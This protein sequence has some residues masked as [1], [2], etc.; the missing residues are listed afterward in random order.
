MELLAT[1]VKIFCQ[2]YNGIRISAKKKISIAE[3]KQAGM[4]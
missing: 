2:A 1:N 4:S 3:R